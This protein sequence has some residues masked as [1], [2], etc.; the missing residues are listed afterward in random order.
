MKK[1][2]L[3]DKFILAL[4]IINALLI[5]VQ[6]FNSCPAWVGYL[7]FLFTVLFTVELAV[8]INTYSIKRY[9]RSGWNRVDLVIVLLAWLSVF[10]FIAGKGLMPLSLVL[11]FR[12]VRI[13]KSIR[14]IRF[15]PD[16][17]SIISGV[18]QAVKA[19]YIVAIAFVILLF[20]V[21]TLTCAIFR[22]I[23]PEYFET[24][25]T[26]LYSIFRLFTVEGWYEI[27][28]LIAERVESATVAFFVKLYFVVFLFAGGV[29]GLSIINSIF[30]D[31]MVS[32]NNDE[33]NRKIDDL[34]RKIDLLISKQRKD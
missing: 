29:L 20:I 14:L 30:V 10:P 24:P 16:V 8:K 23:A 15:V 34:N 5:F 4:I 19:S 22:N 2:F 11:S 9:W 18:R 7:D 32:D 6:E 13:F 12:V 3:N 21:S 31:A 28:D 26:S 27:P 1:L 33:L 17:A 25:V